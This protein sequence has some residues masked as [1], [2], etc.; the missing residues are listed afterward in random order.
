MKKIL[1]VLLAMLVC[2]SAIQAQSLLENEYQRAGR[3]YERQA[4]VAFEEGRFEESAVLSDKAAEEY[5]KSRE[6]ADLQ[7]VKFRAAN[8]INRA[9]RAIM[10]V[11]GV[12]SQ[13]QKYAAEIAKAKTLLAEAKTL[14]R[15]EK[16]EEARLKAIESIEALDGI[17]AAFT[18]VTPPATFDGTLPRYYTVVARPSLTDC[19]WR[20]S[21]MKGV[22][23][24]PLEWKRLW[25][26]NKKSMR[27]PENP[28]LIYPGMVLEIPSLQGENREG[29]WRQAADYPS[30]K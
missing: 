18:E 3:E 6:W 23:E 24:N 29:M 30:L 8:A 12:R 16:W 25:E 5:R 7:L 20:I 26:A 4:K 28:N 17:G 9:E 22:Y 21:A 11:S 13:A 14:Y 2:A 15:G 10:D 1:I 27:D 19:Y